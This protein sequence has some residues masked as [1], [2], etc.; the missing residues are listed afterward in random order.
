[1]DGVV[2][3]MGIIYDWGHRI[4]QCIRK[5]KYNTV[6]FGAG[7]TIDKTADFEGN[8]K[9][10]NGSTLLNTKVGFGSYCSGGCFLK[11]ATIGRYCSIGENVVTICG[12]HPIN[13]VSTHPA[14]YSARK[15]AGF[16]YVSEEKFCEFQ[17]IDAASQTAVVIGNDV[18]IGS[19]VR[20]L[21]GVSI[22][23]GAVIAAG[24]VVTK[25]VPPY[26]I[27]GGVPAQVKKY[28]FSEEE[29]RMLSDLKWWEKDA[30][31]IQQR[32]DAFSDISLFTEKV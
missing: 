17:Y 28:R 27:V 4:T 30:Q 7:T 31:W 22:G 32:A 3:E 9:I 13:F 21:E 23:D 6:L 10:G 15:Q 12:R 19:F 18:W 16:S 11:N 1:M 14:F 26:A 2:G 25:D 29:I 5:R 20:I 8:N 24:A